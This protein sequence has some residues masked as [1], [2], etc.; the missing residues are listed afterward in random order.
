MLSMLY[1]ALLSVVLSAL[2]LR[3]D[4]RV[5][6]GQDKVF[7]LFDHCFQ[8]MAVGELLKLC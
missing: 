4:F 2:L 3:G 1:S 8:L 6:R 5:R 7:F